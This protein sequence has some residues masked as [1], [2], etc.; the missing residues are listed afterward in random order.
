MG[1]YEKALA[2]GR[3]VLQGNFELMDYNSIN[4]V[5]LRPFAN[6][7]SEMVFYA[8]MP[9]YAITFNANIFIDLDLIASYND[10]DLR[11]SLFFRLRPG[12]NFGFRGSYTGNSAIFT[13]LSLDEVYLTNAECE[14]RLGLMDEAK[15]TM[16]F[17]LEKRHITGTDLGL[18]AIEDSQF[19]K[20]ILMERRKQLLFRGVRWSDLKRLNLEEELKTTLRRTVNGVDLTLEPGSLKYTF[21]I[22][23]NEINLTGIPQNPR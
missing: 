17:F 3:E 5:P 11:K 15:T 16:G 22:P 20:F 14:A 9:T 12:N 1:D 8:V 13:G 4:P 18:E 6:F 21:P 7:N 23:P 19:L 2:N 10:S